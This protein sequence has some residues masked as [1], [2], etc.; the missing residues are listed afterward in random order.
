MDESQWTGS[1]CVH[2]RIQSVHFCCPA[3]ARGAP[4]G[5]RCAP[6]LQVLLC[7]LSPKQRQLYVTYVHSREVEDILAGRRPAMEGITLLR[8]IC[9]HADLL[10]RTDL[11]TSDDPSVEYGALERSSKLQL[12]MQ[13][14]PRGGRL[15]DPSLC[16]ALLFFCVF[17]CIQNLYVWCGCV[18]LYPSQ[19]FRY[20]RSRCFGSVAYGVSFGVKCPSCDRS[21]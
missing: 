2:T 8:K 19:G 3:F 18:A 6:W 9:N 12:A 11:L 20:R 17:S 5:G 7:S 14:R 15:D 21:W 4:C 1:S 10:H 13:A 16:P